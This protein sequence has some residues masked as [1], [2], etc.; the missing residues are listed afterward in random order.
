MKRLLRTVSAAA[1]GALVAMPALADVE[2][3]VF[4]RW[5]NAPF[6]P[7]ID[8]VIADFQAANPGITIVTDQVLNDAYKDKIRVVL[9]SSNQPDV[10]FSWSGEWAFNIARAGRSMDLTPMLEADPA[11]RDSLIAA[12]VEPF[13]M[14][15]KVYGVP[16][17]MDGKAIFYNK[18]VFDDLGL[19]E[20]K[21][22]GEL[23]TVCATLRDAGHTPLL[24]GSKAAWAV[25]HYIGTFNERIVPAE[26]LAADYDR[27]TGEFT[28]PG[29]VTALEKF[30]E[31]STCMNPSPNGIDHEAERN[32][33]I[34][35]RGVMSYLQYAEMGFLKAA[36]FP[37]GFFIF[38]AIEGGEGNQT[39][40]QGAPQG[41][42]ISATTEHPEE[43]QKFL[44]FL[45][46][47][48][49]GA[50]L[51]RETGIISPV[52]GAITGQSATPEQIVAFGQIMNAGDPYIWLDT[53]LDATVADAY[54]KGTQLLLD[55][56]KT[57]AEVMADVQAAAKRVREGL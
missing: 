40:L 11:W 20:P 37:Y 49:M 18:T 45:L 34:A 39:S 7:Y 55:G 25:S 47:P 1:L 22:F 42:M 54:M 2:L 5:P 32:A 56:E 12:Q 10:F 30:A 43:A 29:Y 46:S 24:F 57:P 6:K 33:F 9:G 27:A 26:V 53:A 3:K 52:K 35:G 13:T 48:E 8:S 21:T 31:L 16:W 14:D 51:T 36:E 4:H 44:K 19:T 17:Q 38:P 15:G 28:H 23:M 41:W 50:R